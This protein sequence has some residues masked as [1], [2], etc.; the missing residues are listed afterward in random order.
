ML[1][2]HISD[3][4]GSKCE[5]PDADILIHTGDIIPGR[6]YVHD[7]HR[8]E[9]WMKELPH[10][11]KIFVPGN[12]DGIVGLYGNDIKKMLPSVHVLI[13]ELI[14]IDGISI[15]GTPWSLP[16]SN[17]YFMKNEWQLQELYSKI[18]EGTH[19]I[20]SHGPPHGTCDLVDGMNVGS[21]A[22][23]ETIYRVFPKAVLCGHIHEGYGKDHISVIP[24]YNSSHLNEVYAPINNAQLIEI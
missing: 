21:L 3:T 23:R 2:A 7:L 13:D 20:A 14:V 17:W 10:K 24:V 4:H 8:F 19:I 9:S 6:G 15:W 12:H 11:H 22:L 16:F 1:I 5:V 18:P